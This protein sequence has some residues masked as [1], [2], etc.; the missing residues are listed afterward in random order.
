M[1]DPFSPDYPTARGRFRTAAQS[2]DWRLDAQ[3]VSARGPG[4]EPL[5]ID[6]AISPSR[7]ASRTLVVSSGLHGVEGFFGSAVQI[8]LLDRWRSNPPAVRC[9]LLHALN[10]YGFA[11][12][13]RTDER[14]VDLNRNFLSAGES[15]PRIRLLPTLLRSGMAGLRG[16]IAAGQYHDP[17]GLFYGG[18]EP[19]PVQREIE[20]VLASSVAGSAEVVHLDLHTGLG[21][22]G[23]AQLLADYP[24][25]AAQRD[26]LMQC[27]G[28]LVVRTL[29]AGNLAYAARGSFGG[30]C[31]SRNL[32]THYLFAFAEFGTFSGVRVLKRLR[33]ENH[34]H[35]AFGPADPRTIRAKARLKELF[36][37]A[38][39]AWRSRTI[40]A[41]LE[42]IERTVLVASVAEI[43]DREKR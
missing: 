26:R 23:Q 42:M 40:M 34:A 9:V 20:A 12:L 10:P 1:P 43:A 8:A 28:G 13:R 35:H 27:A 3:E 25:H 32:A 4:G 17:R 15:P 21:G 18:S 36:C 14:N 19:S 16:A 38:D 29:G 2:S 6:S 37:P 33:D 24:I 30:W 31:V 39:A 41:A 22:F 11:W 7:D 5:W